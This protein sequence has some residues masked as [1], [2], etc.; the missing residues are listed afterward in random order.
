MRDPDRL[1]RKLQESSFRSR[2]RLNPK[3]RTYLEDRGLDV[4]CG[5]AREFIAK[6]LAP[7]EP[8]NDGRQ[9]PWRG[10]PVFVAQ[11]A[12]ATCCRACLAK[13]HGIPAGRQLSEE[14]QAYV[15]GTILRWLTR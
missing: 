11:H 6:R 3:D 2:F 8:P 7:A 12:T 10:H 4:I 13:W 15:V 1:F 9:T 5:H 14:E